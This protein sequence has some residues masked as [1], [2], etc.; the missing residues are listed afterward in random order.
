M[1]WCCYQNSTNVLKLVR[2]YINPTLSSASKSHQTRH[3]PHHRKCQKSRIRSHSLIWLFSGGTILARCVNKLIAG[4][5]RPPSQWMPIEA[6]PLSAPSIWSTVLCSI[7]I[8]L[9]QFYIFSFDISMEAIL[10]L[11]IN[12]ADQVNRSSSSTKKYP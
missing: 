1:Q 9:K 11:M 2:D 4:A 6:H 12:S 7:C 10:N 8:F 3:S 5:M